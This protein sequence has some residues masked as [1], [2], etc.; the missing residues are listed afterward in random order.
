MPVR[1][2][3][4]PR[5]KCNDLFR[6]AL[7]EC[8]PDMN[9]RCQMPELT[10]DIDKL[11]VNKCALIIASKQ[12]WSEAI[13]EWR[14]ST[15][16]VRTIRRSAHLG[17]FTRLCS[18]ATWTDPI[19]MRGPGIRTDAVCGV[20]SASCAP[21][22]TAARLWSDTFWICIVLPNRFRSQIWISDFAIV[23][24]RLQQANLKSKIEVLQS[25]QREYLFC[26]HI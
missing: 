15:R 4:P 5:Q 25:C 3:N 19:C 24:V 10:L 12:D 16:P 22:L 2:G 18:N 7:A 13:L 9:G 11:C 14:Q 23:P 20:R 21:P 8:L 1:R 26:F 17:R 6:V